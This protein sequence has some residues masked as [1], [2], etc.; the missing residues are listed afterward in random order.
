MYEYINSENY[1]DPDGDIGDVLDGERVK[2]ILRS[3]RLQ[4]PQD[5][6]LSFSIDGARM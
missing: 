4:N 3:G 1:R 6:L 5:F 2:E